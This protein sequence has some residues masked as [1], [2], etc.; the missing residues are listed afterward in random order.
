MYLPGQ[1]KNANFRKLWISDLLLGFASNIEILIIPWVIIT[2]TNSGLLLGIY[3]AVR[4][5]STIFAPVIGGIIDGF[6][7]KYTLILSRTYMFIHSLIFMVLSF[8]DILSVTNIIVISFFYGM[9]HNFDRISREAVTQIIIS[10]QNLRNA[11]AL[12]SITYDTSKIIAPLIG[13][14]LYSLY[15]VSIAYILVGILYLIAVF[16][17]F[18]VKINNIIKEK[19][20]IYNELLDGIK[21]LK[22]DRILI[23]LM[24][25]AALANLTTLT[26]TNAFLPFISKD[27]LNGDANDLAILIAFSALGSLLGSILMTTDTFSYRPGKVLIFFM[28]IWHLLMI[29]TSLFPIKIIMFGLLILFGMSTSISTIL[30]AMLILTITD[31]KMIGKIMGIR[32]LAIFAF[33]IGLIVGG[34]MIDQIGIEFSIQAMGFFGLILTILLGYKSRKLFLYETSYENYNK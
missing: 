34:Y 31:K 18:A 15:G 9:A 16:I 24:L 30:F 13:A 6:N 12:I 4:Y 28:I 20:N 10:K 5:F 19:I 21:Y 2:K 17:I 32:Q 7:K 25:F 22:K 29:T 11:T 1:L 3:G 33:P 26:L 23:S 27:M 8:Q 14:A